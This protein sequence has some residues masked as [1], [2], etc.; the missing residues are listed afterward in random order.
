MITVMRNY[1]KTLQVGLLLVIAA[2]IVTSVVVFGAGSSGVR[3]D[4]VATVN[5][6]S[7]PIDRYERRFRAY[8]D[9]YAQMY[10]DR[11]SPEVAQQMGLAQ[12]VVAD[13]VQEALVVQRATREGLAI[14]DEELN[15]QV[16]AV[17]SFQENGR[18]SMK[19]YDA[20]L[21][22]RNISKPNF[23][24]DIRRQLTRQKVEG[25]VKSGIKVSEAE[26]EQ[27]FAHRGEGIRAAWALVDVNPL[28]GSVTLGDEELQKYLDTHPAEF[29][30]PERRR[31][32]Y[33]AINPKDFPPSVTQ[34]EI[35]KYYEEHA[36]EFETPPQVRAA[37]VLVRIPE[38]GG[39]Q[40]ED[41]AKATVADVIRRAKAGEDF[42]KLAREHSQDTASAVN[43]GDLGFVSKG[44]MVPAFEDALFKLKK[45]EIAPE[46]VRTPFGFHAIKVTDITEGGRT[47]KDAAAAQIRTRLSGEAS[48]RAARAKADEL[49][50]VLQAA[51]DFM[52]E[53]KARGLTPL[54]TIL[55]RPERAPDAPAPADTM[56]EAA[57]ALAPGG[58]SVPIKTPAGWVIMKNVQALPAA[59][60]PLAEVRDRVLTSARRQKAEAMALE[61]AKELAVDARAG[62]FAAAAKK[63]GA[64]AGETPLFTRAK[65]ADRLPGD[66]MLAAIQTPVGSVTDPVRSPQGYYVLKVQERVP[67]DMSAL[68]AERDKLSR[69]VLTQKQNQAWESWVGEARSKA[70]VDIARNLIPRSS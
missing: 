25:M 36:V 29:R 57:F 35:D 12:Q 1:R 15:A 51:S 8:Y 55:A 21:R 56:Q 43:G 13:L 62:D 54:E 19:R 50:P 48:E 42:A 23:E 58:V 16:H 17:P 11:F 3:Q 66:A 22:A 67:A 44:E 63:A 32:Q 65:P 31:V 5:G 30:Q 14:T 64:V 6:E 24:E 2:F 61:R 7:I 41:K 47:S 20:F 60:P 9:A 45:G 27:A 10:P 33:V 52:A 40:A 59:M 34:A 28:L 37:H 39:S 4:G 26:L 53:A 69:E 38:T 46:P 70:K 18:F 49:K 68:S